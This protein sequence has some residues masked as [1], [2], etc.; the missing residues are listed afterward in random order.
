MIVLF[1]EII[2]P[3]SGNPTVESTVITEDPARTFPITLELAVIVKL[4]SIK[5]SSLYPIKS[6]I[7]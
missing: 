4:P 5:S 1:P 2:V 7:L 6:P 3:E